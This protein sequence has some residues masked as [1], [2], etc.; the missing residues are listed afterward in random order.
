VIRKHELFERQRA[1]RATDPFG[2]FASAARVLIAIVNNAIN[3]STFRSVMPESS[4]ARRAT[5][6]VAI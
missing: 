4:P 1:S 3:A 2:G 5:S 6:N